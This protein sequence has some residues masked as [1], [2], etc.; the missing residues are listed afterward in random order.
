MADPF[1]GVVTTGSAFGEA[2][3]S[4]IASTLPAIAC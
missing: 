2:S 3:L 1:A 4:P